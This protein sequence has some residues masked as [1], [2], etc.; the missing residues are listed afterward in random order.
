MPEQ[1]NKFN[2]P[3]VLDLIAE[4]DEVPIEDYYAL[5]E[6]IYNDFDVKAHKKGHGYICPEFPIFN[7]KMEG[8]DEGLYIFAGESN[9]GKTAIMTNLIWNFCKH[10]ENK[11]FGIYY[12]LD[13]N[14]DEVIPRLI[15]MNQR[16]PISVCSKPMRYKDFIEEHKEDSSLEAASLCNIYTDY[17]QKREEGLQQLKDANKEFLILDR[18]TINSFD[19][20]LEHAKKVQMFVKRFD[21]E[22][23]IIIGIDSL[24]DLTVDNRRFNTDKER[25]DYVAMRVKHAA[26]TELKVPIFTTYHVRKL[27]HSGRPTLDDIKE[28]SR[29]VYEA[30]VAFLIFND[31]SKNKQGAS[32]YYTNT[33]DSEKHPVIEMDWAK[34]KKSSYKRRTYHYFVPNFSSVRECPESETTRFDAIIYTK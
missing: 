18:T 15:A 28:S 26:S 30:S 9:S 17:L 27:N 32:V 29:I 33:D 25:I 11:L 4:K 12:S 7:K 3:T 10:K 16:I 14:T 34:N 23:N 6:K 5:G 20:L 8:L 21:P 19:Q 31:V 2:I 1:D 22:N 13:D 24:A